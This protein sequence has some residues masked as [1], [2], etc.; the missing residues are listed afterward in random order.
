MPQHTDEIIAERRATVSQLYRQG[1][2]QIDI[3]K[4]VGVTQGQVSQD[5][6]AIREEW[7]SSMLMD[8]NTKKAEEL[9]KIDLREQTLWEEWE[10]SRK[11]LKKK[12][13]KVKGEVDE[14]ATGPDKKKQKAKNLETTEITEDRIGDPRF[15]DAIGRC[16]E[17]RI[18]ILGLE[19]PI[20]VAQTTPD[21]QAVQTRRWIIEDH[22]GGR[23]V[24]QPDES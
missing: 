21:G 1:W 16:C 20:K 14:K 22:T 24:R 12:S 7:Q 13:T 17:Q 9:A 3:A 8:F 18:R 15:M 19:A 23:K 10:R 5:L 2:T 4:E 11:P 6:D